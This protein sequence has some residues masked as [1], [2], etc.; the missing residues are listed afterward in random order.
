MGGLSTGNSAMMIMNRVGGQE[1]K[2]LTLTK[3]RRIKMEIGNDRDWTKYL[4]DE[5]DLCV[6]I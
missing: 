3:R 5:R 4:E 1:S 6:R 2:V